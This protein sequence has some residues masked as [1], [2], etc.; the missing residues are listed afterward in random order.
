MKVNFCRDDVHPCF[1]T[2]CDH[3]D[4]LMYWVDCPTGGWWKHVDHPE[5]SHDGTAEAPIHSEEYYG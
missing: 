4:E 1:I 5:D 2:F 3:C